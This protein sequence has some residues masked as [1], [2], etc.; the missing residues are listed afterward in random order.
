MEGGKRGETWERR[1]E[2]GRKVL[3]QRKEKGENIRQ[4]VAE[5]KGNDLR[6]G[7]NGEMMNINGEK[8]R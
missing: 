2:K 1:R 3:G 7:I 5:W 6:E 4:E 8:R